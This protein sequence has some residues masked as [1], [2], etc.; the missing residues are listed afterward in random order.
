ME[1]TK[2]SVK[3]IKTKINYI[4]F[5]SCNPYKIRKVKNKS[6]INLLSFG[7]IYKFNLYLY[8]QRNK[9]KY[10]EI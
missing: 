7:S 3:C 5:Y 10:Y 4:F 1:L 2:R 8:Q 6:K 9:N